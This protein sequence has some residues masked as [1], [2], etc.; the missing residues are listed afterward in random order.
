MFYNSFAKSIITYG[1]LIYGRSAK[2]NSEQ[3]DSVQKRLLRARF[4]RKKIRVNAG[5]IVQK[6]KN[7]IFQLFI[8]EVVH[9]VSRELRLESPLEL[10][11]FEE[12]LKFLQERRWESK[13]HFPPIDARTM[14]NKKPLANSLM[15]AHN[16]LKNLNLIPSQI[17]IMTVRQLK[18]HLNL[19]NDSYIV[20]KKD[21]LLIVL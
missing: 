19:F 8:K 5:K 12:K 13:G 10:L 1:L 18:E 15:I 16:S 3:I 2:R 7:T 21:V 9:E 4:F 17:K 20:D 6:Q 11:N 14:K